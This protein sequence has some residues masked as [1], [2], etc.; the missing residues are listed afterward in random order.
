QMRILATDGTFIFDRSVGGS[1][2]GVL[3]VG[4]VDGWRPFLAVTLPDSVPVEGSDELFSLQ[5]ASINKAE[6]YLVSLNGPDP[7]FAADQLFF[8][9]TYQLAGDFTVL[10]AKTPVSNIVF[11]SDVSIDPDSLQ[12]GDLVTIDVTF[13]VQRWVE[14][15]DGSTASPV[16]LSIRA[17]PEATTFGYWDFG[18]ADGDPQFRPTLRIVFTPPTEFLLP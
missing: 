3:R 9:T 16:R 15:L 17:L 1:A 12:A 10:G 7:P 4:G 14:Q 13:L 8:T 11:G 5:R 18:A 6:L 2:E